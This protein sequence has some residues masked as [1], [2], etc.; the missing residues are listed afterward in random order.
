MRVAA[1]AAIAVSLP[2]AAL[3][4]QNVPTRLDDLRDGTSQ[5]SFAVRGRTC[6]SD[7]VQVF[8]GD[9]PCGPGVAHATLALAGGRVA[10][11]RMIVRRADGAPP[12]DSAD[13]RLGRIAAP[14]AAGMLL[15]LAARGGT[16]GEDLLAAASIAD[17][18]V[19]WP[20]LL[21]LARDRDLASD[22]RRA[23]IFWLSQAASDGATRGLDSI[24]ADSGSDRELREHAVFALSQRPTEQAVPAL[25]RIARTNRDGGIRRKAVFWLGQTDDPR[26]LA[27]FEEILRR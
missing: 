20:E 25:I 22:T 4:A 9:C 6:W 14:E 17:S 24:V 23:A 5:L 26:A 1:L 18:A 3:R 10:R 7:D 8:G 2:S 12:S 15:G 13:V 16:D 27:L 11:F 19:V 21:A